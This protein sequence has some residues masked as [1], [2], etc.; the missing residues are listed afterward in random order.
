[1]CEVDT[2]GRENLVGT[3]NG[4]YLPVAPL[5]DTVWQLHECGSHLPGGNG[6]GRDTVRNLLEAILENAVKLGS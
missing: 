4:L 5:Q 3:R 2:G 1:M 6:Q